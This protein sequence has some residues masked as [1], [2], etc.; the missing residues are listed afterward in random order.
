MGLTTISPDMK[1]WM[2]Q[3]NL[4]VPALVNMTLSGFGAP[5]PDGRPLSIRVVPSYVVGPLRREQHRVQTNARLAVEPEQLAGRVLDALDLPTRKEQRQVLATAPRQVDRVEAVDLERTVSPTLTVV[6]SRKNCVGSGLYFFR[7]FT[8]STLAAVPIA[9]C[10]GPAVTVLV[11]ALAADGAAHA[12][13]A[14]Q[15]ATRN[16][17]RPLIKPPKVACWRAN[18]LLGGRGSSVANPAQIRTGSRGSGRPSRP[19]RSP[20]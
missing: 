2:S 4:Y 19:Y 12:T 5:L 7:N 8:P 11:S 13:A 16:P 1:G 6:F 15:A 10:G 14:A 18:P 3:K 17:L 20:R 9:D